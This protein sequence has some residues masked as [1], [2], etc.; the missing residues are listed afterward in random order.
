[1]DANQKKEIL[2]HVL[3]QSTFSKSPTSSVLLEYLVSATIAGTDLKEM[4]IGVDLLG[5]KFDSESGNARIR[6]NIYNLRKKLDN[7]YSGE[8]KEDEWRIVIEKGQ[9]RVDFIPAKAP[10]SETQAFGRRVAVFLIAALVLSWGIF[11]WQT[12][13][14]PAPKFWK[15]FFKNGA[16]TNLIIGD[17]YGLMGEVGT[18]HHGWFR[19]YGINSLDDLYTFLEAHPELKNKVT[20]ANYYYTTEMA[21]FSAKEL[22][23]LFQ[24]NKA[25]FAIRFSTRTSYSDIVLGNAIYVGPI[26]NDNKFIRL[27]NEG[28]PQFKIENN[29]LHFAGAAQQ[30]A[31][32]FNLSTEGLVSEYAI[33]SRMDGGKNNARFVFF[34]DHDIGVKATVEYFTNKD[35]LQAFADRY[36]EGRAANF[37]AVFETT[38]IERNSLRLS[39]VLVSEIQAR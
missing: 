6:V 1:M 21:A 17:S 19:D 35:S 37:T 16:A 26:K 32:D 8:G 30:A 22:G 13:P 25:D 36:F 4:T 7:Y 14:N 39:P 3:A 24:R 23:E 9:Y 10:K 11:F 31:K 27:F 18:G 33:V 15:D 29:Q 5:D 12:R 38:G 34:S 28:N 2:A 20:P